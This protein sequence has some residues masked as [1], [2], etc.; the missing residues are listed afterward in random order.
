MNKKQAKRHMKLKERQL[1]H[2]S[3]QRRSAAKSTDDL[4]RSLEPGDLPYVIAT[5][6][7]EDL[8]P[9]G[10]KVYQELKRRIMNGI[11]DPDNPGLML[12]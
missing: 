11:P 10:K 12:I 8:S 4:L 9:Q 1:R 7:A 3:M 2:E 6:A 5:L